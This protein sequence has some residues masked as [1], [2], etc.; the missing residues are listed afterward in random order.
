MFKR[1]VITVKK[2]ENDIHLSLEF[3]TVKIITCVLVNNI[4]F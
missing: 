4:V 2:I 3:A 1:T